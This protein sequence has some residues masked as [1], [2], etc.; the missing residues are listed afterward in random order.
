MA[1][2]VGRSYDF[3]PMRT[4]FLAVF[5]ISLGSGLARADDAVEIAW[6]RDEPQVGFA[7]EIGAAGGGSHTPGGLRLGG[8]Y[9]YRLADRD[10]FDGGVAFTFGH[11]GTGCGRVPPDGM[12]CSHGA[13]D[14][15]AGDLT[16]GVRRELPAQRGFSPFVRGGGFARALRFDQDRVSGFGLG[17]ELGG[18]VAAA[19]GRDLRVVAAAGLFGGTAW[20]GQGVGQARQLGMSVTMGAEMQLP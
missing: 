7:A 3:S 19:V 1:R 17:L 5:A 16:L 9:L 18:G 14:G 6:G 8:R 10:W 13:V 4:L 12:S 15:F 20:L 2:D 11:P